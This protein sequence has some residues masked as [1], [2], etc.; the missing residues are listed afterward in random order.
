MQWFTAH[1]LAL[2]GFAVSATYWPGILSPAFTPRWA[3]IAGGMPLVSRL[4]PRAVP[5]P[6]RWVLA[7]LVALAAVSLIGSPDP[8]GGT[9]DLIFMVILCGAFLVGAGLSSL[10]DLMT[11]LGAG[12]AISSGFAIAQYLGWSSPFIQTTGISGLFFN[13]EV[14][15]EF[16]ALIFVWA[17]A[18]PRWLIAA[19]A[20]VPVALCH[21][22][23]A[24]MASAVGLLYAF[25]P[26]SPRLQILAVA[27]LGVVGLAMMF[28]FG[29]AKATTADHR[30]VIWG[31]TAMAI[32][33][34]GNGLGW[35]DAAHPFEEFAHSDAIQILAE[36]GLGGLAILAIPVFAFINN[37]GCHAERAAFVAA[38]FTVVVSFPLHFPAAG[39]VAAVLAGY[40]VGVRPV[41]RLGQ[42]YGGTHDGQDILGRH[43]AG[44][45]NLSLGRCLDRALSI[46]SVFTRQTPV[47]QKADRIHSCSTAGAV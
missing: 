33:P 27:V 19:V 7:F 15:A 25:W 46:R 4:D 38:C 5:E 30:L 22:R 40:L 43:V 18:R 44:L 37:R 10:D 2:L 6:L 39:F 42:S 29:Q 11:G 32:T 45:G 20:V 36:L 16:S 9:G 31:A 41:V 24:I 8:R 28:V 17:V 47:S 14:L 35:F 23:I 34:F 21:S 13:S 26:R 12:L 1:K 3:V